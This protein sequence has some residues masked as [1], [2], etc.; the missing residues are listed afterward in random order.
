[1]LMM[2]SIK[3]QTHHLVVGGAACLTWTRDL[4]SARHVCYEIMEMYQSALRVRLYVLGT[5]RKLRQRASQTATS[6]EKVG[7]VA[8]HLVQQALEEMIREVNPI[9]LGLVLASR[10][11]QMQLPQPPLLR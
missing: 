1:V 11:Q 5:K 3:T 7:A 2:M 9:M 4:G 10:R 6:R 8:S